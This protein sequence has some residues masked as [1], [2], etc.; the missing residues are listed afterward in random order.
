MALC[1]VRPPT[2]FKYGVQPQITY[3]LWGCIPNYVLTLGLHPKL[4]TYS[5]VAS[6]TKVKI[7]VR[8]LLWG[9]TLGYK[10]L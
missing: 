9:L 2:S 4:R 10:P 7:E 6:Q 3:L 5:G 1:G 8:T